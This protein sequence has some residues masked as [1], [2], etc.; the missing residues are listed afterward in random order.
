[1]LYLDY[2]A[3]RIDRKPPPCCDIHNYRP[4]VVLFSFFNVEPFE[5]D[6]RNTLLRRSITPMIKSDFGTVILEASGFLHLENINAIFLVIVKQTI[7]RVIF[8]FYPCPVPIQYACTKS[9]MDAAFK[10]KYHE[11]NSI[12]I[13]IVI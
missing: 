12:Y 3:H 5:I 8:R 6:D 2:M 9:I 11:L 10:N 13:L 7:P 1:M 4:E